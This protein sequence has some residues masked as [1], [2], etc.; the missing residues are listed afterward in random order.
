MSI[1]VVD[2]FAGPGGLGEGFSALRRPSGEPA[3]RIAVSA[4][5]ELY[6]A[7]TLK[8]RAF[9]RQFPHGEVPDSY[10]AYVQGRLA[11]PYTEKT[12]AEWQRAG[13]EARRL[14]L[15]DPTDDQA[16]VGC[17][18]KAVKQR[19]PWVLIGGPPCQAY[20][21]VGRARNRGVVGYRAED[22]DRHF[23]YRHYL[24]VIERFRP[25]IFVMENVKGI[26]S[27]TVGGER[28]FERILND[29]QRPGGRKGPRYRLLS[30]VPT[31]DGH[32]VPDFILRAEEFGVP[33]RRHR[34]IVL[35]VS[36]EL[37]Q[38]SAHELRPGP[39]H[40]TVR[41]VIGGL[42]RLRSG[43][44]TGAVD[45]WPSTAARILRKAASRMRRRGALADQL[46]Q[47]SDIAKEQ[48]DPDT[49][50]RWI[51]LKRTTS[52]LPV[53]LRSWFND[54]RLRGIAN[55]EARNH[56][57]DDLVRYGFAAAFASINL[58][59]PRGDDFPTAL[60]PDH[61]SWG[62]GKFVDRFKVQLWDDPSSTITSHL[63]K[64]GHYFI[65]PDPL[66]LRSLTVREAARLQTFPDNYFFE[67]PRGAQ[68]RQ[69]GNAVPPWL[70]YQ[71]AQ[72]VY[73]LLA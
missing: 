54:S 30:L 58:R 31:Q 3:F 35:G 11:T 53:H 66:Q 12:L 57:E 45:D 9:F 41:D 51:E 21:L 17:I 61:R 32:V 62:S 55:H 50:A 26:L 43:M 37:G 20:S 49:G 52:G 56:M 8:L 27:S 67:G 48:P 69:V 40:F 13:D 68:Y 47:L 73:A 22:D 10:Y 64:D 19:V 7:R 14:T 60:A 38:C 46:I 6:A 71:I 33:Q 28:V 72:A 25:P 36:E 24:R 70:A 23:L 39:R 44:T 29:L 18:G 1:S 65:H 16:L 5:M 34:V 59:S 2:L 4:E 63:C 15:G 42:P